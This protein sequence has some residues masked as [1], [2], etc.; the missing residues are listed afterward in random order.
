M[1]KKGILKFKG[2]TAPDHTPEWERIRQQLEVFLAVCFQEENSNF[3]QTSWY[4]VLCIDY[5]LDIFTYTD[6]CGAACL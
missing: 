4:Q 2:M 6:K 1:L 3:K 5:I